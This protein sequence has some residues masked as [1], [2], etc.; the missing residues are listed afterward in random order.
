MS[1]RYTVTI[2]DDVYQKLEQHS[3]KLSTSVNQLIRQFL[4]LGLI[5]L[6][7]EDN[8]DKKLIIRSYDENGEKDEILKLL[9]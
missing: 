8:S 5:V 2:P 3:D 9:F 4:K 1:K 7:L 6:E